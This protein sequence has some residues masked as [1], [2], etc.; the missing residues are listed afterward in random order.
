MLLLGGCSGAPWCCC[1]TSRV[2]VGG[3]WVVLAGCFGAGLA[4][5][6]CCSGAALVLCLAL[7]ECCSRA[8]SVLL[9]G[10]RARTPTRTSAIRT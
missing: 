1:G 3:A 9:L 5:L 8:A 6:G 10:P 7:L 4:L 2:L